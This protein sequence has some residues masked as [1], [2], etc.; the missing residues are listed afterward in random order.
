MKVGSGQFTYGVAEGW[1]VAPHGAWVDSR[2]D[3]YVCEVLQGQRIQ[4]FVRV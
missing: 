2:G 3:L 1:F 4:K